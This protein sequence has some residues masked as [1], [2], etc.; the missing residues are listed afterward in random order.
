MNDFENKIIN[1]SAL[2]NNGPD[3]TAFLTRFR[4]QQEKKTIQKNCLENNMPKF[5]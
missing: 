2:N 5:M 1:L 3:P 4:G